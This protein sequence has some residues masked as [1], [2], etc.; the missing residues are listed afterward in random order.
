MIR[1]VERNDDMLI[2]T[3]LSSVIALAAVTFAANDAWAMGEIL[4][5]TKEELKLKYDISVQDHGT[6]RVTI[7]FTLADEGRLKPLDAIELIILAQKEPEGRSH[8]DLSVSLDTK[9]ADDGNRVARVH[10]KRELAER[11]E[12]WLTTSSFDGKQLALTYYVHRIPLGEHLK[13]A[14]APA[15]KPAG[16]PI[17]EPAAAPPATERKND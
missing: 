8:L 3:L 14:P 1:L 11:A 15:A 4:G 13:Y 12:L 6:G 7:V 16:P 2:R 5:Q 10:I 17:A 9:I